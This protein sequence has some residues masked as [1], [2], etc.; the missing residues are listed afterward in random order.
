MFSKGRQLFDFNIQEALDNISESYILSTYFGITS[1]P[2]KINAPYRKDSNPSLSIYLSYN[3]KIRYKDFGTGEGGSLFDLLGKMWNLSFGETI[4]KLLEDTAIRADI[5]LKNTFKSKPVSQS[6]RSQVTIKVKTRE[7]KDWDIFY[8]ES[9]GISLPW[10]K[11]GDVYPIS[12]IFYIKDGITTTITADKYAYCYVEGKDNKVTIKVYQ[13][14]SN[15]YK[16]SSKHDSSVWDLWNKLPKEGDNL[17][18]TSSRKDALCIWENTGIPC[19]SLQGEGYIPK[20]KVVNELKERFKNI[21]ILYDNDFNSETNWGRAD[22]K[23]LS[24]LFNLK[25]IEIPE[26]YKSKDPSDLVKNHGRETLKEV[27]SK[28]INDT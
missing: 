6:S 20:E 18:I 15:K 22:G 9:Y 11:F 13:P 26:Q 19:T 1:L 2:A 17:I 10:L 3:N 24:E 28:L 27:I 21:Y 12:R 25:Q 7:W 4:K 23:K 8:W 14:Y 5:P 16:W